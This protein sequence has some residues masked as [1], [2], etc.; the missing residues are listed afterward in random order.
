MQFTL[1]AARRL[2]H[3]ASRLVQGMSAWWLKTPRAPSRHSRDAKVYG[4]TTTARHKLSTHH[5]GFWSGL[6]KIL[7]C[8]RFIFN[9]AFPVRVEHDGSVGIGCGQDI[10][11][12]L[13]PNP[14]AVTA[15]RL[16]RGRSP[17]FLHCLVTIMR[18]DSYLIAQ[19]TLGVGCLCFTPNYFR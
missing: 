1:Y 6:A 11:T 13:V 10:Y 17:L 4:H 15:L 12:F 18:G 9:D 19:F 3:G 2:F 5:L 16:C 8:F 14:S 7:R